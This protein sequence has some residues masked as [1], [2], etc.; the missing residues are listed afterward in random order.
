[1]KTNIRWPINS[2]RKIQTKIRFTYIFGKS[3]KTL[4]QPNQQ[5]ALYPS[6]KII[7]IEIRLPCI[8]LITTKTGQIKHLILKLQVIHNT[9]RFYYAANI[10]H[11]RNKTK[12]ICKNYRFCE[13]IPSKPGV[14]PGEFKI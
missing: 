3:V 5:S 11:N 9:L 6:R 2:I 1:M 12:Q 14:K 7:S 10:L 4:T 13:K 8:N